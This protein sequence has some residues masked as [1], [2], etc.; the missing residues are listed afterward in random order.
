MKEKKI[1]GSKRHLNKNA[2]TLSIFVVAAFIVMKVI[3]L[4]LKMTLKQNGI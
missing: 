2:L 1:I 3:G 4:P